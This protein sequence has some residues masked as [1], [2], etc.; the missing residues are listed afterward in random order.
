M[1]D[2]LNNI[3]HELLRY[4]L[5]N[6]VCRNFYI[7]KCFIFISKAIQEQRCTTMN[8]MENS[9]QSHNKHINIYNNTHNILLRRI[10]LLYIKSIKRRK[11]KQREKLNK[12]NIN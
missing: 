4:W 7:F 6:N 3:S 9:S 12:K 10:I 2:E 8:E 5:S 11:Q 1:N